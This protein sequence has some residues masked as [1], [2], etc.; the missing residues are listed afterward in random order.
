MF[1]TSLPLESNC[2]CFPICSQQASA[3]TEEFLTPCRLL[4]WGKGL[5]RASSKSRATKPLPLEGDKAFSAPLAFPSQRCSQAAGQPVRADLRPGVISQQS[6]PW[7]ACCELPMLAIV[8]TSPRIP[9]FIFMWTLGRLR[10]FHSTQFG[11]QT[12]FLG[13][14]SVAD[15]TRLLHL[16]LVSHLRAQ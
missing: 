13:R 15:L 7:L 16:C 2:G 8:V 10:T 5:G 11:L 9:E 14:C 3:Y 12:D 1:G 4:L 6:Q